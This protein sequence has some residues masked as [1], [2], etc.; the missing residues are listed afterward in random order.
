MLT[1]ESGSG[2]FAHCQLTLSAESLWSRAT[3]L[4]TLQLLSPACVV[5]GDETKNPD[6]TQDQQKQ[7]RP[8]V[9]TITKA[10]AAQMPTLTMGRQNRT[11]SCTTLLSSETL[12]AHHTGSQGP[13]HTPT[14]YRPCDWEVVPRR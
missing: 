14:T 7:Q 9:H 5:H 3:D 13:A 1:S 10:N 12:G 11:V 4:V 6:V 2:T 8:Q